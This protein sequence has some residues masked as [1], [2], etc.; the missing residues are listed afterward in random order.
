MRL[1]W[2]LDTGVFLSSL[3]SRASKNLR[4]RRRGV[5]FIVNT[6]EAEKPSREK[7]AIRSCPY[8]FRQI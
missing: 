4:G 7:Y 3:Q 5:W 1:L 8:D 2:L 6:I